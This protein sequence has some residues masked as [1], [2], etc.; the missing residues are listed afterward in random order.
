MNLSLRCSEM[1]MEMVEMETEM[2]MVGW[3]NLEM[4]MEMVLKF[5]FSTAKLYQRATNLVK[6]NSAQRDLSIG[7]HFKGRACLFGGSEI[8]Q[9]QREYP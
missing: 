9:L 4:E 6:L 5:Q 7:A 8:W 1:E 2:E 3:P